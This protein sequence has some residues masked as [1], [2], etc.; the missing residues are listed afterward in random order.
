MKI[1]TQNQIKNSNNRWEII[2]QRIIN[3]LLQN[4]KVIPDHTDK[5][6]NIV[7]NDWNMEQQELV[8]NAVINI[9]WNSSVERRF[10]SVFTKLKTKSLYNTKIMTIVIYISDLKLS[11]HTYLNINVCS[12]FLRSSKMNAN[13][14]FFSN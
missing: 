1:L 3:M 8:F 10:V 11:P 7:E 5:T 6:S 12:S 2:M 13:K 9:E 14:I 4:Y